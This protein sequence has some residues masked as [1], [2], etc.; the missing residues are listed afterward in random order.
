M[1]PC[2]RERLGEE[3]A[4][5]GRV[6]Q[7]RGVELHEFD[8]SRRDAG[9]QRHGHAVAGGLRRVGGDGEELAGAAGGQHH[10]VGPDLDDGTVR[11]QGHD[12]P[13]P[14]V[15]DEEIE[16]EPALEHG[17][18]R[19]VGGIDQCPLHFGAGRRPSGVHDARVGVPALARQSEEPAGLPIELHPQRDQLVHAARALV[20]QDPHRFFVA[21]PGPRRQGV[22]QVEVGGVL[23]AAQHGGHA[24]LRP[25][26]G[27]LREHAL[28]QDAE[29]ARRAGQANGGGQ[30]GHSTPEHQD[31]EGSGPAHPT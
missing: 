3:G 5:H 17:P 13:A 7:G 6:V 2:P 31:V 27:R 9:A 21:E 19:L 29:R 1:A 20:D 26:G 30:S 24:A 15:L 18:G 12:A 10:V 23:V 8:I 4:G 16:G 25:P 22:G 28:G 14:S 11:R